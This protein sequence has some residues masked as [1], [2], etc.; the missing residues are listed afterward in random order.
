VQHLAPLRPISAHSPQNVA[1]L[2][3]LPLLHAL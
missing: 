3:K 1:V 2:Q